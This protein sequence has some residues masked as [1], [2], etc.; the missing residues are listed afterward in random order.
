MKLRASPPTLLVLKCK[1]SRVVGRQGG[2]IDKLAKG[3]LV[4]KKQT[5]KKRLASAHKANLT[6]S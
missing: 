4:P 5:R 2:L 6:M 1:A 3:A